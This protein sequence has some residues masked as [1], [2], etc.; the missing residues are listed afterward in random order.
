MAIWTTFRHPVSDGGHSI[1]RWPFFQ[2]HGKNE[3]SPSLSSVSSLCTAYNACCVFPLH[4]QTYAQSSFF[5]AGTTLCTPAYT[6]YALHLHTA[7][8]DM[9]QYCFFALGILGAH[10]S[11][12][13]AFA[14][15][16]PAFVI[17]SKFTN[18]SYLRF[19]TFFT[20]IFITLPHSSHFLP[21][22]EKKATFR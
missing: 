8:P 15:I 14:K 18:S 17:S 2:I 11:D 21:I 3:D 1:S 6:E 9:M 19:P 10:P 7:L 16:A 13:A 12:G 4:R 20:G 22:Y 5:A